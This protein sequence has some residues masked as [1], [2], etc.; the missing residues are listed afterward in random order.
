[1]ISDEILQILMKSVDFTV[2]KAKSLQI[3]MKSEDFLGFQSCILRITKRK[4]QNN[5]R[6]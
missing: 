1:M 3:L 6:M 5:N 2:F 4:I